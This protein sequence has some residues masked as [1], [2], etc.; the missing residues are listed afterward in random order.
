MHWLGQLAQH[1][2]IDLS[3]PDGLKSLEEA[4]A[5]E[6]RDAVAR[7]IKLY[8]HRVEAMFA[9]VLASLGEVA[10]I[11]QEDAGLTHIRD[12][13][14]SP[15][16][17]RIRLASGRELFIEVKTFRSKDLSTKV[18][19]KKKYA[20]AKMAY[21]SAWDRELYFAFW[22]REAAR[23]FLLKIEDFLDDGEHLSLTTVQAV[24]RSRMAELGDITLG[25]APPLVLHCHLSSEKL[26]ASTT[27]EPNWAQADRYITSGGALINDPEERRL[28][29]Y[30]LQYGSW[31][32]TRIEDTTLEDNSRVRSLYVEPEEW[33][34]EQGFAMI[35]SL[36]EMTSKSFRLR[37]QT[38]GKVSAIM[39]DVAVNGLGA[40]LPEGPSGIDLKLWRFTMKPNYDL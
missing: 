25:T 16:D 6:V 36:A 33:H 12:S 18:K 21:A 31:T 4:V 19:L 39:P 2:A 38:E 10:A 8:G 28:A 24:A 32:S 23:W 11:K 27:G 35:G 7:P 22:W 26:S 13:A 14:P 3:N 29:W 30:L 34:P 40:R 1:R 5:A 9:Y 37:T 15:P 17:Y 20:S